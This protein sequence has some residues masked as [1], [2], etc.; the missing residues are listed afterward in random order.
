MNPT[1]ASIVFET[2][3]GF[4]PPTR[5]AAEGSADEGACLARHS[6]LH[7]NIALAAVG[8]VTRK[9]HCR[10]GAAG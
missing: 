3:A 5:K 10:D 9:P 8:I 6:V 2:D 4:G 7:C 1:T